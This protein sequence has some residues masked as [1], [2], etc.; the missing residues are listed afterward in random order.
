M[1]YIPA[2]ML[3]LALS[4][5]AEHHELTSCKGPYSALPPPV[6]VAETPKTAPIA[7]QPPLKAAAKQQA[8]QGATH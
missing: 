8:A 1:T 3:I 6:P 7:I 4:G 2:A 5:C